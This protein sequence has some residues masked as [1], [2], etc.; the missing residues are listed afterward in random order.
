M[1][2]L[3]ILKEHPELAKSVRLEVTAADLIAYSDHIAKELIKAK[4]KELIRPPED[5]LTPEEFSKIL[6]VSLPT[7]W[8]WDKKGITKP[9][10]VGNRKYYKRSDLE[11]IMQN[12]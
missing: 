1:I 10:K 11:K 3:S 12:G 6:K 2:D 4:G 9:L 8:A 5:Y 7:L